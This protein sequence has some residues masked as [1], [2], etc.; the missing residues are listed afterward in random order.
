MS[1]RSTVYRALSA[2]GLVF[3][4]PSREIFMQDELHDAARDTIRAE[5]LPASTSYAGW[6]WQ[7]HAF[8]GSGVLE[9]FQHVY[10][11]G[12]AATVR[13][14]LDPLSDDEFLVV[15]GRTPD[16]P[17]VIVKEAPV[18]E[19][20]A[21]IDAGE[22]PAPSMRQAVTVL[23][24][25]DVLTPSQAETLRA[26][27]ESD[28]ATAAARRAAE[29]KALDD[30]TPAPLKAIEQIGRRWKDDDLPAHEIDDHA[31]TLRAVL[32]E[33]KATEPQLA[34][35]LELLIATGGLQAADIAPLRKGWRKRLP[36]QARSLPGSPACRRSA[37]A[38]GLLIHGDNEEFESDVV[39]AVLSGRAGVDDERAG[40]HA[41][42]PGGA[43]CGV[44]AGAPGR[45][46]RQH[47]PGG[48]RPR[49]G[50]LHAG[51]RGGGGG[52]RPALERDPGR[53]AVPA[54]ALRRR[55]GG[56]RA[57]A[58]D[59]LGH[60]HLPVQARPAAGRRR[61]ARRRRPVAG[62]DARLA[63]GARRAMSVVHALE[64]EPWVPRVVREGDRLE[65]VMGVDFN[66]GYDIREFHFPL[67]DEHLAALRGSLTRH[68]VLWCVLQPLAE[69][70]GRV[71]RHAKPNRK[72]AA[73]V[74]D[75][76]LLGTEQQVEEYVA[77]RGL[78]SYQLQPLVAHGGDPGLVAK[79]RLF[80]ALRDRVRASA[81]WKRVREHRADEARA[82]RGIHLA[83]ID[84]ALLRYTN[85]YE[86]WS[87]L[88]ARRP[89]AVPAPMLE[90]V[91]SLVTSA[92]QG[93]A[94]TWR[95]R[96]PARSGSRPS[97]SCSGAR[98]PSS[99]TSRSVRSRGCCATRHR[100]GT[101]PR[102]GCRHWRTSQPTSGSTCTTPRSSPS[103]PRPSPGRLPG[104]TS[105]TSE[106]SSSSASTGGWRSRPTRPS[107]RTTC[108]SGR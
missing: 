24:G 82:E 47:R 58:A 12:D 57:G 76:V 34:L 17:F 88:S 23:A 6:H 20:L 86:T 84:K 39:G 4:R 55:G 18:R 107:P 81:D 70:A 14:H 50:G 108:G 46:G 94:S 40:G 56:A 80:E 63:E 35:A 29:K 25:Y 98:D 73:Q 104:R 52:R 102:G 8:S 62:R 74:I 69:K 26:W 28:A 42:R 78:T 27:R 92:E 53:A 60:Q 93:D 61:R 9:G 65:L 64:G 45:G 49:P 79:G 105:Y 97:G 51:G 1:D 2:P 87:G 95:P 15:G 68:L 5:G 13:A 44:R 22:R 10:W 38:I 59:R 32:A 96:R 66:R 75:V 30:A 21:A 7:Q 101:G 85:R 91:L 11:G 19:A 16:E 83:P 100:R 77:G 37:F 67:T 43:R 103:V 31:D 3:I 89:E 99:S 72:Q 48:H 54:R 36:A 90:T 41:G 71:D 106:A 33:P